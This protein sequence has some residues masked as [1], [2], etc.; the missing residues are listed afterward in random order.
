[1]AQLALD[2]ATMMTVWP[3]RSGWP[4]EALRH[5]CPQLG[6]TFAVRP[7][8]AVA[9]LSDRITQGPSRYRVIIIELRA[10]VKAV[11]PGVAEAFHFTSFQRRLRRL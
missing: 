5:L 2:G 3:R 6:R 10:R 4:F 1:M 9:L 8:N 7:A 11:L